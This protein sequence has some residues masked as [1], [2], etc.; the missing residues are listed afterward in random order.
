MQHGNWSSFMG[1]KGNRTN[2]KSKLEEQKKRQKHGM[3]SDKNY[4]IMV[5]VTTFKRRD[6]L[7]RPR[8]EE[9]A[10]C[11][12]RRALVALLIS[13]KMTKACPRI[14]SVFRATMSKIWPNWEKM[15]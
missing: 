6:E 9:D 13:L 1:P 11:M 5:V 15:A 8:M 12:E 7:K 2:G 4:A 10:P 14:F 3:V